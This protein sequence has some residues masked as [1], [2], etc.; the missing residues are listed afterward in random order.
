MTRTEHIFRDYDSINVGDREELVKQITQ[1]DIQQFAELTGDDNPLHVDRK[2]AETTS[3]KGVVVHGML[4]ASFVSTVIGT[5]L[6]GDGAL[7][8]SQSFNFLLPVRL[9]DTLTISCTVAKKHPRDRLLDL[10]VLILNQDKKQ[11]LTGTSRVKLLNPPKPVSA[12]DKPIDLKVAI[13]TGGSGGIGKAVCLQL[14]KEGYRVIV[15][16]RNNQVVAQEIV[17]DIESADGQAIAVQADVSNA[18][19]VAKL[20]ETAVRKFGGLT[21]VVNTASGS[22]G[23]RSFDELE[24]EDMAAHLDSQVKSAYLLAKA[25]VDIM[26]SQ[27]Y[28]KIIS[29]TSQVLDGAPPATWTA[30]ATAKAALATFSRALAVELGPAGITVNCVSPSMTETAM[31]GD[32]PEKARLIMARQTPL[33][34]L[35]QPEDVAEAVAYLA[36]SKADFI[37]GETIRVNGGQVML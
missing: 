30:Y 20:I 34:R 32:I 7:W 4:S 9:N 35:A 3:F 6:P 31:I 19:D 28:G 29:I 14:G 24:W 10:D 1:K 11:V 15:N 12:A 2:F 5:K 21:V 25:S 27:R 36:S 8:M 33:R 18:A 17:A 22:I 23:D 13:V 16:Y 26:R 37:T